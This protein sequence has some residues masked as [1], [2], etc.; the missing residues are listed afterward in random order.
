MTDVHYIITGKSITV[1]FEGE[2]YSLMAGTKEYDQVKLCI[3]EKRYP[4]IK[5]IV[6][7]ASVIEEYTDGNFV[8]RDGDIF[9][10]G[11]KLPIGLAHKI[12]EFRTEGLPYD[13]L[14][15]FGTKILQNPSYRSVNQ[16]FSFLEKN[17]HPICP[18]G[19]F[20]A[21][22]FVR[23]NF[24]DKHTGTIDN[25]PGKIVEMPRNQVNEDPEQTC[26]AGLHAANWNYAIDFGSG[27]DG[28]MIE[29]KINPAD[30]VAIPLDYNESKMRVCRY[31]VLGE[32]KNARK[33][34]IYCP[35]AQ[36]NDSDE[37]PDDTDDSAATVCDECDDE[38]CENQECLVH[39]DSVGLGRYGRYGLC[40]E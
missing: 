8:V 12:L 18:D 16:L 11:R 28:K 20:I 3:K 14:I 17:S 39:D 36:A 35:P 2:T 19:D 22:K 24:L 21:Y 40:S 9:L 23:N 38:S 26:S 13:S 10:S 33:E 31:L 30:V 7:K 5:G 25:S 15:Q 29:L 34:K 4:D 37:H 27:D 6:I 32:V 1:N